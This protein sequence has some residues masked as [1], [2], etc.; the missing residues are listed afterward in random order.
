M[1][2]KIAFKVSG[3][4]QGVCFR[5]YTEQAAREMDITC[6]VR[7]R[8]DGTVEGEAWAEKGK[9]DRFVAWLH[10]GSPH[11]RV[12]KVDIEIRGSKEERPFDFQIRYG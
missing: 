7:N 10:K 4:V 2:E 12:D 5:A 9:I 6:W 8:P 3:R 1:Y 11:G